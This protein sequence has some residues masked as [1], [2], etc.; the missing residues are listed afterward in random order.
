MLHQS[1][2]SAKTVCYFLDAVYSCVDSLRHR[3]RLSSVCV[4]VCV[5]VGRPLHQLSEGLKTLIWSLLSSFEAAANYPSFK[6]YDTHTSAHTH[7]KNASNL[8]SS[9]SCSVK[10]LCSDNIC[11]CSSLCL[12]VGSWVSLLL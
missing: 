2:H 8:I 3:N 10:A 4:C 9:S 1:E 12:H 5:C 11:L 7:E 6:H